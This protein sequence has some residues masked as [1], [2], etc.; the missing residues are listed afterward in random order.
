MHN[1][2][3]LTKKSNGFTLVELLVVMSI[4]SILVSLLLPAVFAARETARRSS[5]QNRLHQL[6]LAF[7]NFESAHGYLQVGS[8]YS[9]DSYAP[10]ESN[11][12]ASYAPQLEM[13]LDV[14][15]GRLKA[16]PLSSPRQSGSRMFGEPLQQRR[17]QVLI[18]PSDPNT[19]TFN[20]VHGVPFAPTNWIGVASG[21]NSSKPGLFYPDFEH[22]QARRVLVERRRFA[23]VQDGISNTLAVGERAMSKARGYGPWLFTGGLIQDE[24]I[25]IGW[26]ERPTG[27]SSNIYNLA[28]DCSRLN[29]FSKADPE[30]TCA[31]MGFWSH[32]AGGANFVR[33]D[34]S[35]T[36][37]SYETDSQVLDSLGSMN[38][39]DI[40]P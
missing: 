22:L 6:G 1:N 29:G 35:T 26:T 15:F 21:L 40:V 18:C 11:W 16:V 38:G 39:G 3:I 33:C 14:E 24:S 30:S 2:L 20:S 23:D 34:G 17:F 31:S 9:G 5:C 4:I 27:L 25:P 12:H 8:L 7:H 19:V 10:I 32:H 13:N 28:A 37:L 36:F